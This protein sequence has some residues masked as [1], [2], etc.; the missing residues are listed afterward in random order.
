[1]TPRD[2]IAKVGGAVRLS[3]A[4]GHR[5]HSSVLKWKSIPV[6]HVLTIEGIFGIPREQLRPDLYRQT[7]PT[8]PKR[9]KEPA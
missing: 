2:L 7:L 6:Q 3:R 5:T 8:R 9:A 1:M 4:L